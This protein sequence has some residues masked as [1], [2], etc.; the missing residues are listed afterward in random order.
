[1]AD[2]PRATSWWQTLPGILTATGGLITAAATLIAVLNQSGMLGQVETRPAP[3]P[4]AENATS[5]LASVQLTEG[6]SIIGKSKQGKFFDL[7]LMVHGDSPAIGRSY[8]VVDDFRLV[9]KRPVS[10][11]DQGQVIT[12]G[13]VHRGDSVKV[14][15]LYIETPSTELVPVWAKLGAVLHAR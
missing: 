8:D 6:W 12:L 5:P 14:L 11:E 2:E 4:A 15:D 1:M 13:M 10:G 7:K 9:H 3:E